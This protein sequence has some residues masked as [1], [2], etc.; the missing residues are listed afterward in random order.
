VPFIAA[1]TGT[2]SLREPFNRYIF[3]IRASYFDD[4]GG[5]KVDF[6]ANNHNGSSFV[7]LTIISK[8]KQFKR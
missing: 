2:Q 6:T 1:F 8:N 7:D 3:N 5:Y 4:V